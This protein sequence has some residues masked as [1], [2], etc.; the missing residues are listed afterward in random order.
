MKLTEAQKRQEL[1][2]YFAYEND[3]QRFP[4]APR[5]NDK[6]CRSM[7]ADGL[8]E[9]AGISAIADRGGDTMWVDLYAIT[10]AGRRALAEQEGA[11]RE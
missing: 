3:R 11:G 2:R 10:D 7:M 9:T 6:R 8:L 1:L 5:R 4:P